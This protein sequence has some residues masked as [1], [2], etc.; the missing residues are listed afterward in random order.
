M[1]TDQWNEDHFPGEGVERAAT[2]ALC[3]MTSRGLVIGYSLTPEHREGERH[4]AILMLHGFPGICNNHD[5]AMLF[6]NAGFSVFVP[7]APGAWGSE[8]FYSFDGL[9][10]AACDVAEYVHSQEVCEKYRLD[11]GRFFLF[12]H[13][14]GGYAAVNAAG[15]LPWMKG[16]IFAAPCNM[17]WECEH[18]ETGFIE[19]LE[20]SSEGFLRVNTDLAEN[21]KAMAGTTSFAAAAPMLC[22]RNFLLIEC[23]EDP[24][25]PK[26]SLEVL[27]KGIGEGRFGEGM[28][29]YAE[30][31]TDHG[32]N[33]C[34]FTAAKTVIG[35]C[36]D[37][38]MN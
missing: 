38:C 10:D 4:P 8:G 37:L 29:R 12:G 13:S 31:P 11:P 2:N 9:I 34:K 21:A 30:L 27:R 32:F 19:S 35:F 16:F 3:V 17:G 15:R 23:K 33:S 25:I 1:F 20:S 14:M 22:G 24:V 36:S 7:N 28:H 18:P 6:C 26:E 5:L